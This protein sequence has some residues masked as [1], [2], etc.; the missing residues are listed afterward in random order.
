MLLAEVVMSRGGGGKMTPALSLIP[1]EGS[2]HLPLSGK[3]SR[4]SEQPPLVC[5]GCLS[6]PHF[7]PVSRPLAHPAAQHTCVLSRQA[8][9]VLK[10][11]ILGTWCGRDPGWSARGGSHRA[12]DDAALSQKGTCTNTQELGLWS[13]VLQGADV[14][15]SRPRQV[16]LHLC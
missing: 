16:S 9:R 4:K 6:D 13:E 14:Q 8:G 12:G 1:R 5:P 2:P 11:R 10:L 7:H 15:V 3:L